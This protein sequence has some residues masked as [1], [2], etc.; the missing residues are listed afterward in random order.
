MRS[1]DKGTRALVAELLAETENGRLL[2]RDLRRLRS[3]LNQFMRNNNQDLRQSQ[4]QAK[5][6]DMH[7]PYGLEMVENCTACTLRKDNFFCQ[8]SGELLR[9]FESFSHLT[10][11][12]GGV[13]LFVEGQTP[14][15]AFVLCSGKV[16]F[17]PLRKKAKC[18]S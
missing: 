10:S 1:Q 3:G 7:T 15:G 16:R 11:Y 17:L 6:K 9:S 12:P 14:R 8:F 2:V 18:S 13:V 4:G 5:G